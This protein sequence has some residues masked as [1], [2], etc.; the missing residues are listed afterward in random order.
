MKLR[1]S[2]I[3]LTVTASLLTA[4]GGSSSGGSDGTQNGT[5]G[6]T[7]GGNGNNA[8][9]G[10]TAMRELNDTGIVSCGTSAFGTNR[11]DCSIVNYTAP[12][13]NMSQ[14]IPHPQ[15]G[16][17]GRDADENDDTD[18][19]AGFSFTKLS[20]DGS[21]LAATATQTDDSWTCTRDEV[22]GLTWEVKEGSDSSSPRYYANTFTWYD[23]NANTNGTNSGT[24]DGGSCP[25]AEL[26]C[27]TQSLVTWVND[28]GGLC[29][30]TDGWRLPTREELLGLVNFGH[31]AALSDPAIDTG[32]FPWTA[33]GSLQ[34]TLY[35]SGSAHAGDATKAWRF[36]FAERSTT[37]IA[38]A[39]KSIAMRVRLVHD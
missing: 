34:P 36:Y 5:G 39:E 21:A 4:C 14:T 20:D 22:T 23:T 16:D 9:G 31:I 38:A 33:E 6:G 25:S 29:G 12:G 30:F 37:K 32:Y 1:Y 3:L 28:N 15:D 7:E 18:G 2:G 19:R 13:S 17:Q 35:W 26:D 24:S 27:D 8:G 10:N 11:L